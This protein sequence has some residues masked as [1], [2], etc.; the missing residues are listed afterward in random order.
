MKKETLAQ[1]FPIN[2]VKFL[3]TPFLKEYLWWLTWDCS[4]IFYENSFSKNHKAQK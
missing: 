4:D 3:R 2:F 1:V